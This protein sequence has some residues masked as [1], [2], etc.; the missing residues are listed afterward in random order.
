M[1]ATTPSSGARPAALPL[2]IVAAGHAFAE[3]TAREGDFDDWIAAGMDAAVPVLRQD[4]TD[5]DWPYPESDTL[6]G[7]IVTGSHAMVT[8]Q[9]PW[10]ERLA[11]WLRCCVE[12]DT[13]LLGICYGHQLLAHA[14]G[15]RVGY[16]PNG[17]ELGTR[18]IHLQQVAVRDALF[19]HLPAVFP[20]QLVHAQSVLELPAG[21]VVL[22]QNDHDA[23]QAYRLGD[24]TWGV[25]FHPEFNAAAMRYYVD[26]MCSQP[27]HA[28]LP[29]KQLIADVQHCDAASSLL[30]RFA[31]LAVSR[32]QTR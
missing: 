5:T 21:A 17:L 6:A 18:D 8:D 12:A 15:G 11:A 16:N 7:V 1:T 23:H 9:E 26:E 13:P 30:R 22:A 10:S 28:D 19:G 14:L 31:Q 20:A 29:C 24:T 2:L 27:A 3:L 4:A 32:L 25:Q